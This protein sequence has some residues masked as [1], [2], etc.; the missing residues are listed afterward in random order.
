MKRRR[1]ER[2]VITEWL[3]KVYN[4]VIQTERTAERRRCQRR[5]NV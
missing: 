3:R 5:K 4:H 2:R 1:K